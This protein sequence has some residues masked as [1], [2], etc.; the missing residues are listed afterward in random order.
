MIALT[1][2]PEL[3]GFSQDRDGVTCRLARSV[4]VGGSRESDATERTADSTFSMRVRY[5]L[6][7]DGTNSRVRE[8]G[9]ISMTDLGFSEDWLVLDLLPKTPGV[10]PPESKRWGA[11]QLCDP[12]QP[13]TLA[14]AGPGR[15]RLEFMRM[16]GELLGTQE[17]TAR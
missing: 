13:T 8:L 12:D 7:C 15:K 11:M 10:W 1:I 2:H 16:P 6:G 17:R 5:L 14:H 9:G 4:K 3:A